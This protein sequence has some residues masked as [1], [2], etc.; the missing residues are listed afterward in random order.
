M[1]PP[2]RSA[3]RP[4]PEKLKTDEKWLA[5][6]AQRNKLETEQRSLDTDIKNL[7][8]DYAKA[9]DRAA[10]GD[11]AVQMVEKRIEREKKQQALNKVTFDEDEM[12]NQSVEVVDKPASPEEDKPASPEQAQPQPAPRKP[13]TAERRPRR[14][15]SDI[16]VPS[17]N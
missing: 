9:A 7:E 10:K 1:L 8:G 3:Q 14:S 5:L 6:Q 2:R 15:T 13:S 16:V 17:P 12:I 4:I 11:L